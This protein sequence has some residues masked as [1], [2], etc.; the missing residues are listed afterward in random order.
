M[1]LGGLSLAQ[2]TLLDLLV[3]A[4]VLVREAV[5]HLFAARMILLPL[6]VGVGQRG[7]RQARQRHG[8]GGHGQDC[9]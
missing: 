5:V 2:I 9:A 6:G 8:H 3:N 1:Q 4:L 7:G